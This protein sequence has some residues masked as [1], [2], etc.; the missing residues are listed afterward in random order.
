VADEI[1]HGKLSY[2]NALPSLQQEQVMARI[3]DIDLDVF[4]S[5]ISCFHTEDRLPD[6]EHEVWSE[7]QVQALLEN[8]C[9]LDRSNP[10]TGL[11]F[12]EHD[13]LFDGI[14]RLV[15]QDN[16]EV[17]VDLVHVDA[18]AD[19]ACGQG[20]AMHYVATDLMHQPI[21]RRL[22]PVRGGRGLNRG[23]VLLFLGACGWLQ[24]LTYV[25]HPADGRDLPEL[26]LDYDPDIEQFFF[27]IPRCS[28]EVYRRWASMGIQNWDALKADCI[29]PP[30]VRV[31]LRVLPIGELTPARYDFVT[32]TRS[33]GF[34]PRKADALFELMQE[35]VCRVSAV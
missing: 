6:D 7:E 34:T 14:K 12:E 22:D 25:H 18:H 28:P 3:L 19:L 31:P 5:P 4:V 32:L 15:Q 33:P 8:T 16:F 9:C 30:E 23:T 20:L 24:S 26:F 13:E 27:Q 2:T 35:Y 1:Q 11:V 10:K 29:N 21:D 17:P